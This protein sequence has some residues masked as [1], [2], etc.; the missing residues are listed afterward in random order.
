MPF[1]FR[2][3]KIITLAKANPAKRDL[4]ALQTPAKS[5]QEYALYHGG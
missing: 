1:D 5:T 2:M 3:F 4:L